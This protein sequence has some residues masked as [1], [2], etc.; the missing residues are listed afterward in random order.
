MKSFQYKGQG[1]LDIQKAI[2]SVGV[3]CLSVSEKPPSPTDA[4]SVNK[5][6]TVLVGYVGDGGMRSYIEVK[7]FKYVV[8]DT[9]NRVIKAVDEE[10]VVKLA[11]ELN[12]AQK[13]RG[14]ISLIEPS[15]VGHKFMTSGGNKV[16]VLDKVDVAIAA[17]PPQ[18]YV[19]ETRYF[20]INMETHRVVIL[21]PY[22][23]D[24][25]IVE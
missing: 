11:Q 13:D 18:G 4:L 22:Q 7:P 25:L 20:C 10:E 19:V 5:F 2:E 23:L 1:L 14:E 6:P 3:R 17:Q 8:V 12:D 21:Q 15:V 24:E 16:Q 9:E